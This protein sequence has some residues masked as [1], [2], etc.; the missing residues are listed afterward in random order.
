VRRTAETTPAL[1]V[2]NPLQSNKPVGEIVVAQQLQQPQLQRERSEFGG[3]Q[4]SKEMADWC[5][6]Q[7]KR[8]NGS[9]DITLMHFCM[10]LSSGAEIR[11]TLSGYLGSSPQVT[12]F[13]TDFI[14]FREEGRKPAAVQSFDKTADFNVKNN[15]GTSGFVTASKKKK[16][17]GGK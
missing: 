15:N 2:P 17:P 16:A 12:N 4:M 11:E 13:A 9:D 3:K 6:A 5:T 10:S 8:L 14:K 1:S 7:L